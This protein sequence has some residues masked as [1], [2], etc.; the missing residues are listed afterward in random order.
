MR[1]ASWTDTDR[2]DDGAKVVTISPVYAVR[3][4]DLVVLFVSDVAT[5]AKLAKLVA[6]DLTD[7]VVFVETAVAPPQTAFTETTG[8]TAWTMHVSGCNFAHASVV[9][10]SHDATSNGDSDLKKS[11]MHDDPVQAQ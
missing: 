2:E 8:G 11:E 9:Q 10:A 7:L 4:V 5:L 3:L 6:V 1:M